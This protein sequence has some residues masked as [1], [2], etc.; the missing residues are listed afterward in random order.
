LTSSYSSVQRK[1]KGLDLFSAII[2]LSKVS[3]AKKICKLRNG[4]LFFPRIRL[5]KK[6]VNIN[7]FKGKCQALFL[8]VFHPFLLALVVVVSY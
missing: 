6:L 4:A 7:N 8:R 3:G 1:F 2:L 5:Y